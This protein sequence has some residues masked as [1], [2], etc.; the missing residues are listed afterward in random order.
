MTQMDDMQ[1]RWRDL[2][3]QLGLPPESAVA[4]PVPA[5]ASAQ[6]ETEPQPPTVSHITDKP[7]A[8]PLASQAEAEDLVETPLDT[9]EPER[10]PAAEERRPARGRRRG[11]RGG[12]S[13]EPRP[14]ETVETESVVGE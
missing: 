12:R 13:P 14:A 3:E 5:H 1:Q 10:Q 4:K 11:R 9:V 8:E 2:A 7:V 6:F